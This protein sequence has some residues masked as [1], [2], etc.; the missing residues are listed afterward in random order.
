M[1]DG[2]GVPFSR[3]RLTGV[4]ETPGGFKCEVVRRNDDELSFVE[5]GQL[6]R[7]L[8]PYGDLRFRAFRT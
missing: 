8:V 2:A 6:D 1:V 7:R 4:Y 5:P 3:G